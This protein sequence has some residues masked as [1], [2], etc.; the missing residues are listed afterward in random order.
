MRKQKERVNRR[1]ITRKRK[2]QRKR[3]GESKDK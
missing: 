3:T 2:E 1:T